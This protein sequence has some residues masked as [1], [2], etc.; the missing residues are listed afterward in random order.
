[1]LLRLAYLSVTDAFALLRLLPMSDR[2]KDVEILAL[3]HQITILERQLGK[4]RPRFSPGDRAFLAA[5][6]VELP[7]RLPKCASR[8]DTSGDGGDQSRCRHQRQGCGV[9]FA[10]AA[11]AH[12][13]GVPQ[14]RGA[15]S[16]LGRPGHRV[17]CG[18]AAGE[19]RY[20]AVAADQSDVGRTV[21]GTCALPRSAALGGGSPNW[22]PSWPS[23]GV[24]ACDNALV[25]SAIGL[26]K[27]ELI[28]RQ[29][30]WHTRDQPEYATLEH[31][32]WYHN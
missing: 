5:M 22:R 29:G 13:D 2:D 15:W 21:D 31:I 25:E 4:E 19:V 12:R 3:R 6:E 9:G 11:V 17:L 30:L 20:R 18:T 24:L 26:Y 16:P 28:N 7:R 32:D 27:I 23:I 14:G 10:A 1:M 8:V